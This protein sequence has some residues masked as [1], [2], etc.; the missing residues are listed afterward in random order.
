MAGRRL[1]A[2]WF[3][4]YLGGH[5]AWAWQ[6]PFQSQ[7]TCEAMRTILLKQIELGARDI[8]PCLEERS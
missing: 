7:G 3:L 6:G 8:K 2:W 4:L 5:G 1:V